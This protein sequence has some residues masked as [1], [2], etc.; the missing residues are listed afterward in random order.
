MKGVKWMPK[1]SVIIP[2]HN[3]EKYIERAVKS[4]LRQ[5]YKDYELIVVDDG[6]TD[7]TKKIVKKYVK[8]HPKKVRYIYQDN[9]GPSA[10][11][12]TGIRNAQ[13][14]YITFLDSDDEYLPKMLK[15]QISFIKKRPKCRFL[16]TWYYDTDKK[17]K[18]KRKRTTK[19]FRTKEALREGLFFR[20]LTI[21]TSTVM[22]Q[23][24]V[25]KKTGLFNENYW[26]SQDWDM[27][28]RIAKYH[29]GYC[30][31]KPL[32]KYR[33]HDNNRSSRG[34][35]RYHPDIKRNILKLYD[36]DNKKLK[37]LQKKY[38]KK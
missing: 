10:A 31:R 6:S 20:K 18:I 2:T 29:R 32:A 11:R 33:Q 19:R 15:R 8:R 36:W 17:G 3:R 28:L 25:F 30:I 22:I 16:Y 5:T 13:G 26:Y 9:R 14:K 35:K 24:K 23:K 1:V 4:V 7:K 27:W 38:G 12:N 21:R 37:K 34:I